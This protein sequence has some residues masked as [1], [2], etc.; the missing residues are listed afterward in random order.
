M[1]IIADSSDFSE[2]SAIAAISAAAKIDNRGSLKLLTTSYEIVGTAARD[3]FNC[4]HIDLEA[5]E[6]QEMIFAA[7]SSSSKTNFRLPPY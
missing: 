3:N 5:M 7:I 4:S 1:K 2:D 6:G